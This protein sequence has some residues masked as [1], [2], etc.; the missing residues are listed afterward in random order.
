MASVKTIL[1]HFYQGWIDMLGTSCKQSG[2][3]CNNKA[4]CVDLKRGE[5]KKLG[6]WQRSAAVA[7]YTGEARH[8]HE[9]EKR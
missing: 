8:Q 3:A 7:G 4:W 9:I 1:T 2:K 6:S 5:L